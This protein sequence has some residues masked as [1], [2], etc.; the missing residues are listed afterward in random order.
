MTLGTERE[1][2][3]V[4]DLAGSGCGSSPAPREEANVSS[5]AGGKAQQRVPCS[6]RTLALSTR[7]EEREFYSGVTIISGC[8]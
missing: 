2:S 5:S 7:K 6:S 8:S 1:S 3:L 4:P